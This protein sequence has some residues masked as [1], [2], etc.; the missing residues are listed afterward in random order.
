MAILNTTYTWNTILTEIGQSHAY[1]MKVRQ[2]FTLKPVLLSVIRH[3][4]ND[5]IGHTVNCGDTNS[6]PFHGWQWAICSIIFGVSG[7]LFMTRQVSL[8]VLSPRENF[9]LI[10]TFD[11]SKD[12]FYSHRIDCRFR[13]V[14]EICR[15]AL[16]FHWCCP[17]Q[18][19]SQ[20]HKK[21]CASAPT[22]CKYNRA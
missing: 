19:C 5:F 21:S 7:S 4:S 17:L 3:F 18:P 14:Y 11:V 15:C 8:Y 9:I 22:S 20:G 2:L 10:S 6:N 12:E 1:D 13:V 16:L